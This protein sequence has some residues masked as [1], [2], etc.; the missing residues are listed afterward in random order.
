MHMLYA[1]N[2]TPE[3]RTMTD[4]IPDSIPALLTIVGGAILLI[5]THLE[6]TKQVL[7]I[8]AIIVGI[9]FQVLKFVRDRKLKDEIEKIRVDRSMTKEILNQRLSAIESKIN[10]D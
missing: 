2:A 9:M 8:L 5:E 7:A 1:E 4:R 3:R 10:N 6:E